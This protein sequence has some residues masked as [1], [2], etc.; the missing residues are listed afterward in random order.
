MTYSETLE[1]LF[2][3]LPMF[4]R[5]G[6]AAYKANLDNTHAI[7]N[8]LEHPERDFRCIHIA[9]TNGKGSVSNMLAAIL[10]QRGYKTGL[11]TS[12]HL[13]DFRERIRINGKM[14]ERSEVV[15]FVK[16]YKKEFEAIE[17]S[18]F[19]WTV[20]LAFDYFSRKD[21]DIAVIETGLG[22][23]LD[24][25]NVVT[26]LVSVITNV[27]HDH[28][29]LL[30]STLQKIA[31]E[32]SGIIKPGIPVVIGESQTETD[33][34]FRKKARQENSNIFFADKLFHAE[35]S[36][37]NNGIP[38]SLVLDVY[39]KRDPWLKEL[40]L[41][42]GGLY[43]VH[44][45]CT[46]LMACELLELQGFELNRKDIRAALSS[47]R[48]LTG[49]S[50]R[51][52]VLGKSPLILADTAHNT[53]GLKEVTSQLKNMSY[54]HLHMVIGMVND[55]EVTKMLKLLPREATYYFCK[56]DIPRGLESKE[57]RIEAEK[58]GLKGKAYESVNAALEAAREK[59]GMEDMIY[60][61][62][63]TFVVAEVV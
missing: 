16:K 35:V 20:G 54:R 49:F 46:T 7:M 23:R 62:G 3:R 18:F 45:V 4:Q 50:G 1:Y 25:T 31:I 27:Q 33:S 5:I 60:T 59:A 21:V 55:K 13:K 63:S 48:K 42:L 41:D 30:G 6:P 11:Y 17:P 29:A 39:R 40:R 2:S 58:F 61:G 32:K 10:Q 26:P 24:S 57:L 38:G 36:A 44:N 43:Q 9:G 52:Q 22:G 19:E 12:P 53:D 47:V 28:M 51:W 34:V 56:P 37:V 14:I 8:L 15:T